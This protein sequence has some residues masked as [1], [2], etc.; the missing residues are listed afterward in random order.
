M[1]RVLKPE[2]QKAGGFIQ[3]DTTGFQAKCLSGKLLAAADISQTGDHKWAELEKQIMLP[4]ALGNPHQLSWQRRHPRGGQ[5]RQG[6]SDSL[7]KAEM[8]A[9]EIERLPTEMKE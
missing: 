6:D 8:E 3:A 5:K 7:D 1:G 9:R 4:P 2:R